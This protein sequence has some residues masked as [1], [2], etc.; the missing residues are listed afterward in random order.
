MDSLDL[1][2]CTLRQNFATSP[3]PNFSNVT[4]QTI[5]KKWSPQ[6]GFQASV[7]AEQ[8]SGKGLNRFT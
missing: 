7:R 4:L 8:G 1:P 2:E 5:Q 3:K 6:E